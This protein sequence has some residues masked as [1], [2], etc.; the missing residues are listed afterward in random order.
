M[1]TI[2]DLFG[3]SDEY[4][5]DGRSLLSLDKDRLIPLIQPYDG[6]WIKVVDYPKNIHGMTD[7][8]DLFQELSIMIREVMLRI[9]LKITLMLKN[10][11]QKFLVKKNS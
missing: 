2:L 1:P 7:E 4:I 5:G 8:R 10:L 3:E 6:Q 9:I 11:F